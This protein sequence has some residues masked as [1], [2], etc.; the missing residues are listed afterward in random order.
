MNISCTSQSNNESSLA[1][2]NF[3]T[4]IADIYIY[5]LMGLYE[6]ISI[7]H[8]IGVLTCRV[9]ITGFMKFSHI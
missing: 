5:I 1:L 4:E 3:T 2:N 7:H 8:H 9:V 6:T